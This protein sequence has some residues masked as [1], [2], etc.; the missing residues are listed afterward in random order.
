MS[1]FA[2]NLV[3]SKPLVDVLWFVCVTTYELS[4]TAAK[5]G[6]RLLLDL[7]LDSQSSVFMLHVCG[8]PDGHPSD[9]SS[10][11]SSSLMKIPAARMT[12]MISRA[13]PRRITSC[14]TDRA[15]FCWLSSS[16]SRFSS[17]GLKELDRPVFVWA[18]S[19]SES[20][21]VTEMIIRWCLLCSSCLYVY[22]V[23][24]IF[25]AKDIAP[26]FCVDSCSHQRLYRDFWEYLLGKKWLQYLLQ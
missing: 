4:A 18:W 3:T 20:K 6:P 22:V 5:L 2:V 8:Q 10:L 16:G 24:F 9:W 1:V 25:Y 26:L 19:S 12:N 11:V 23:T 7:D 21:P 13:R 14:R 17:T 15:R